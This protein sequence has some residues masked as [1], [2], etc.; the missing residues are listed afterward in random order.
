MEEKFEIGF[1]GKFFDK[2]WVV[3]MLFI[4]FD[5]GVEGWS[6]FLS[7]NVIIGFFGIGFLVGLFFDIAVGNSVSIGFF[8]RW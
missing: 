7:W 2:R 6:F 8:N 5:F 4:C 1:L 3:V